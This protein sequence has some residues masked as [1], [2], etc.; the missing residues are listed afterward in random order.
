MSQHRQAD[1]TLRGANGSVSCRCLQGRIEPPLDK[2]DPR[3]SPA[4]PGD[5]GMPAHSAAGGCDSRP[6][7]ASTAVAVAVTLAVAVVALDV[8]ELLHA[9][10]V[11]RLAGVDVALRVDRVAVQVRE[12]A[13]L[14]SRLAQVRND[15]AEHAVHG[16]QDLV[17]AV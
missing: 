10:P 8:D 9:T 3:H 7:L 1:T 15:R 13:R 5:A 16:V 14:M 6:N 12:L 4:M 11:D 2:N 17:S